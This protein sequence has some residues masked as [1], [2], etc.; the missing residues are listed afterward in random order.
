[1]YKHLW[2]N[3]F[4][5]WKENF[6]EELKISL[7]NWEQNFSVTPNPEIMLLS[8]KNPDFKEI[9]KESKWN[10]PDWFWLVLGSFIEK[11]IKRDQSPK[12]KNIWNNQ[13][14]NKKETGLGF[15]KFLKFFYYLK[16]F[17]LLKIFWKKNI[18]PLEKRIC[19]SDI[20]YDICKLA[21]WEKYWIY[22]IWWAK[23]VPQEVKNKLEKI[24]PEIKIFWTFD[25][26]FSN[27]QEISKLEKNLLETNP[28]IIFVAMWAPKQEILIKKFLKLNKKIL[29][30]IWIWWT[31]DFVIW[32]QKR[33]PKIMRKL[34]L[35]WIFRLYKE[36]KRIWRI[37]DATFWYLR[38]LYKN[39]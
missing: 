39:L 15:L 36:P 30:W 34:W 33:A 22:L 8:S 32:K 29:F 20:F 6:L 26:N 9:L 28:E 37:Y 18:S 11:Q 5:D 38:M 24:Y 1:M 12:N 2:I 7:K 35:E 31:F 4:T 10:L 13:N 25:W 3:F 23:W 19:W 27:E 14:W 17:F 16:K 21:E